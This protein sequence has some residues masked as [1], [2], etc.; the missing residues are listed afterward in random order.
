[1]RLLQYSLLLT[2]GCFLFLTG[3][4]APGKIDFIENKGQW[5]YPVKFKADLAGGHIFFTPHS[6]RHVYFNLNDIDRIHE[7]KHERGVSAYNEK[8]DCYAYEVRFVNGQATSLQ[9]EQKKVN[10]YNYFIGNDAKRWAGGVSA[11]GA[12]QYNNVYPGID[13]KV[14]SSADAFKYDVLVAPQANP[15]Q[16]KLAYVGAKPRL[17][18]NGNLQ[19]PVG[20]TQ[21][22]EMKPY[23]YQWIDG[24]Q[25]EVPS[26]YAMN[27]QG[28][29]YYEFPQGYNKAYALVI[30]PTLVF[31][32]YSGSSA[33]TFGFSATYDT[34]G[35]LYAGGECFNVGWPTT[36]GAFQTVYGGGVECGINKYTPSGNA[37]IYS[38]Y[39]GGGGS[40]LPNNLVVNNQYQLAMTGSTSS[41]NLPTTAGCYDNTANGSAD[42]FVARFNAAGTALLGSTY[43][44]GTGADA[45]NTSVLSPN[46]GDPNRGEIFYDINQQDVLVAIGSSSTN[47]PTTPG[48]YQTTNAGGQDGVFFKMNGNCTNLMFSTYIGGA[49]D[50]AC[51]SIARKSNGDWVLAG[52]T[53]S[54][55]FP[56]TAGAMTTTYQNGTDGFVSIFNNNATALL[57]STYI[58]TSSYDHAFKVQVAQNDTIFV[59]GQTQGPQFPMSPGVYTNANSTIYLMKLRPNL[60]QWV[61]STRIGQTNLLVPTAFLVDICGNVYFSGFQAA[62]GLP[63]TPNAHQTTPGGF[64]LAVLSGNFNTLIYATYMGAAGDHVDGGTSRFDPQGIV[65]QSVCTSSG[66]QYQTPGCYMPTKNPSAGWDVASFK[67]DFDQFGPTAGLSMSNTPSGCAPYTI[68]FINSSASGVSYIWYFGDGGTDTATT[69]THTYTTAGTFTVTLVAFN[70]NGCFTS[71]TA[72]TTVTIYPSVDATFSTIKQLGCEDDTVQF[73]LNNAAQANTQFLWYF[74]DGDTSLMPNPIHVYQNQGIYTITCYATNGFCSDTFQQVVNLQHPFNAFYTTQD[75]ICLGTQSIFTSASQPQGYLTHQWITGDGN[76]FSSGLI[77]NLNYTYQAP[78]VYTTYLVVTDTIGCK[79]TATRNVFVDVRGFAYFWTDDSV[80]CL[81]D[82]LII[83]DSI[84]T[85]ASSFNY[86]FGDGHTTTDVHNPT[87]VYSA[88]GTYNVVLTVKNPKCPDDVS[89]KI[90][91]VNPYPIVNLGSDTAYC[92]GLT[93]TLLLSNLSNIGGAFSNVWNTGST[94]SSIA[95]TEPGQYWLRVSDGECATTDTIQINRD[96]YLNIPNAFSPDGDGLNE[97]FLPREILSS[98]LKTFTMSIYNRWGEKIF[99]TTSLDGRGWDGKYNGVPQSTGVYV[100]TIDVEFINKV[101]KTYNGN[102]TLMR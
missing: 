61:R 4:A 20:F 8:V 16:F 10:Y 85:F 98:G 36:V 56:T 15:A 24:K 59:C 86:N 102:V 66:A 9:T 93:G 57:Q 22:E 6:F 35:S 47:F 78:G 100:Y 87:Y 40:D 21:V 91:Q 71:D 3:K 30:D 92:P 65:Y 74:G 99:T 97:F 68:N 58:G 46:Y 79:D 67:F 80:L 95:V 17:A 50:D 14:Y 62:P 28:E 33:T 5:E 29:V 38:T 19:I 31:A 39:Y 83:K 96:C 2:I 13:V 94:A 45:Q 90:I 7:L 73:V 101:K 18:A 76:T 1:M 63:L 26:A 12:V 48:A 69:P 89:S 11:Y 64:W 52:G 34:L 72:T 53:S 37:L 84:A 27:A 55:N 49:N 43:I 82:P 81:G 42:A 75:S 25:V 44:G 51:F 70:P 41:A 77:P 60:S 88:P 54:N 32:T 23:S